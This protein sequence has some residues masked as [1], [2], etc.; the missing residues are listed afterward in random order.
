VKYKT[1]SLP[2]NIEKE[3]KK[4]KKMWKHMQYMV[5]AKSK[6]G[7]LKYKYRKNSFIFNKTMIK[8]C[9]E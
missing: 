8:H 2:F 4:V 6:R 1:K 9:W 5:V 3:F 7:K